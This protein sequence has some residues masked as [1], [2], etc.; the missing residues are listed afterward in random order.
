MHLFDLA[1]RVCDN[2]HGIS[3]IRHARIELE[4]ACALLRLGR[5]DEVIAVTEA[6]WPVLA[7]HGQDERLAALYT[8]QSEALEATEPGS[9]R[10][11]SVGRLADEWNAYSLGAGKRA[12]SCRRKV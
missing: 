5:F 8:M 2:A 10:A 3:D 12:A 6:I 1:R 11:A 4:S 7:A 9:A